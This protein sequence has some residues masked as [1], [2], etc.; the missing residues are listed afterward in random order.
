MRRFI[1]VVISIYASLIMFSC[2]TNGVTTVRTVLLDQAIRAAAENIENSVQ[3]GQKIAVLNFSS[4]SEQFSAYV[5]EELS[6]QLVNGRRLV[7]VDRR[8]LELIRQE[9]NFQMSGEVSYESAQAI[10]KKLGAQLIVSGSLTAMGNAYRFRIRVLNVESA[11]IEASF[12]ADL[13]TREE[14]RQRQRCLT[15]KSCSVVYHLTSLRV[16]WGRQEI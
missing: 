7:V 14:K 12:P 4:P 2:V 10:G 16:A 8:E 15:P 11:A 6:D 3:I 5:L 13:N 1:V 9:E